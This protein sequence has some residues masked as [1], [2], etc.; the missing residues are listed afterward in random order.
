MKFLGTHTRSNGRVTLDWQFQIAKCA[1]IREKNSEKLRLLIRYTCEILS[2]ICTGTAVGKNL[3]PDSSEIIKPVTKF[4]HLQLQVSA[5][6]TGGI[7]CFWHN[8]SGM[9]RVCWRCCLGL[10]LKVPSSIPTGSKIFYR[11]L[12]GFMRFP[13]PKHQ[14]SHIR[15]SRAGRALLRWRK[16]CGRLWVL[17]GSA[18]Q[19]PIHSVHSMCIDAY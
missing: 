5:F 8:L 15:H 1:Q 16:E 11:F 14:N 4:P 18:V 13:V 12:C 2:V 9:K 6:Q 7:K 17:L 3:L 10:G 19:A